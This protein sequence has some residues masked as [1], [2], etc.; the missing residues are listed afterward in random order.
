[1]YK[2]L[3]I[4]SIDKIHTTELGIKRIAKHLDIKENSALEYCKKKILE[5]GCNVFKKG[6]NFYC[7]VDNIVITINS[8]SYTIITAHIIEN[9]F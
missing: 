7:K 9:G 3:L 8:H 6:K 5:E 4:D 1:M 2:K